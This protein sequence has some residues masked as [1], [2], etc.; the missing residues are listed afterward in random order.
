MSLDIEHTEPVLA[1][2][3]WNKPWGHRQY[4]QHHTDRLRLRDRMSL[5]LPTSPFN[6]T[7]CVTDRCTAATRHC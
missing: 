3:G 4:R 7:N 1:V 2:S 5:S 6:H